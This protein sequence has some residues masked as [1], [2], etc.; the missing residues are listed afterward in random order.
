MVEELSE[1][2][3]GEF[4]T[5][6]EL[7][8]SSVDLQWLMG[9]LVCGLV[10]IAIIY[11]GFGKWLYSK[12]FSYTRPH[13]SRFARTA[14]LAVFA[15]GLVTVMNAHIQW[16]TMLEGTNFWQEEALQTFTKILN[17]I[18]ILVIGFTVSQLIPIALNKAEKTKLEAED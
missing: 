13:V 7:L 9:A 2:S 14:M 1:F 8:A 3:A 10:V 12:E 18:N 6:S 11:H 15:I 17:T 5:V 16:E 4:E